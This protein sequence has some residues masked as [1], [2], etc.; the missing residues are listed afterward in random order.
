MVVGARQ[1]NIMISQYGFPFFF[2]L[3]VQ[4]MSANRCRLILFIETPNHEVGPLPAALDR[5]PASM[6]L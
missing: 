1:H 4:E 6:G 3:G 5:L 2:F